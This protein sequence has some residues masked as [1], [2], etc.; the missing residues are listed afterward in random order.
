MT[1][2]RRFL[3]GLFLLSSCLA[4]SQSVSVLKDIHTGTNSSGSNPSN[5]TNVGGTIFFTATDPERGTEL[6]KTDGTGAGTVVVKDINQGSGSSSP[7]YLTAIG[8]TV[9]F[10][11]SD[12]INGTELWKSDGTSA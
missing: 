10:A 3:L 12:G 5:F 6:W 2:M 9:Y 11:A 1:C 8:T 4:W 7:S